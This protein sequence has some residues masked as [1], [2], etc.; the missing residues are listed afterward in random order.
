MAPPVLFCLHIYLAWHAFLLTLANHKRRSTG[1][2][3]PKGNYAI[4][5]LDDLQ[6]AA[7][8]S[9]PAIS[10][11]VRQKLNQLNV[12]FNCVFFRSKVDTVCSPL[13]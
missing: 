11:V 7:Q 12:M 9:T 4:S 1:F 6:I 5:A 10:P 3:I 2:S 8:W 13:K